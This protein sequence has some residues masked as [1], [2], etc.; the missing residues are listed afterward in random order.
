[1]HIRLLAAVL[2]L[3]PVT[4]AAEHLSPCPVSFEM[5]GPMAP[6]ESRSC[7]CVQGDV[8]GTVFG[9]GRYGPAS[10][11]CSAARHAGKVKKPG[12]AVTFYRQSD[13]PRLWG[14]EGNGTVSVNWG[15]PTATFS[16]A[17]A[18]P[19]CPPA[20]ASGPDVKPC[21]ATLQKLTDWPEGKGFDCTCE[22][23]KRE[24][25]SVWGRGIYAIHSDVCNAAQQAGAVKKPGSTVTVFLG[26]GCSSFVGASTSTN[27]IRSSRWGEAKRSFAFR[28]PYPPCADGRPPVP[29][30]P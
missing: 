5:A 9:S 10:W 23:S 12:D 14:S 15:A 19:P 8:G 30:G 17:A 4:A 7:I 25:G 27:Y 2:C 13:C 22:W 11:L 3:L 16:F 21:P 20:P 28:L 18:P 26:G 1:M 6:G 29:A 24:R